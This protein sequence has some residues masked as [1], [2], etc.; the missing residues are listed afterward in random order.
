MQCSSYKLD[1]YK[2]SYYIS[3]ILAFQ[4]QALLKNK[5]VPGFASIALWKQVI[6]VMIPLLSLFLSFYAVAFTPSSLALI[7]FSTGIMLN[8]LVSISLSIAVSSVFAGMKK[9][10]V[11]KLLKKKS[12]AKS[13]KS[14]FQFTL[15]FYIALLLSIQLYL[16]HSWD[17]VRES[18][19]GELGAEYLV[20]TPLVHSK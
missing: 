4:R 7:I 16:C 14:R 15:T 17:T 8:P 18:A 10:L 20:L 1:S 2:R 11:E 13:P 12:K 6:A 3:H 9:L 19:I 5:F